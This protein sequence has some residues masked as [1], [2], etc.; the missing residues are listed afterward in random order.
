MRMGIPP[1]EA[2]EGRLLADFGMIIHEGK[3]R[4]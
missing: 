2:F 1:I 3:E 4:E